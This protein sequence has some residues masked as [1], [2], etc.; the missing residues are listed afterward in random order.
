MQIGVEKQV[1]HSH[2]GGDDQNENRNTDLVRD[3]VAQRGDGNVGQR[4][5][6]NGGERQHDA[7]DRIGRHSQ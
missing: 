6:K 5:D 4:H 2:Q 3:Q 1:D 7:I